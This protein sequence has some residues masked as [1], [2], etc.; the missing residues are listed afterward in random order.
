MLRSGLLLALLGSPLLVAPAQAR[1][2]DSPGGPRLEVRAGLDIPKVTIGELGPGGVL[3]RRAGEAK[4]A[5]GVEAGYDLSIAPEVIAGAYVGYS[6]SDDSCTEYQ[7]TTV[8]V[9]TATG[10][11]LTAGIRAGIVTGPFTLFAKGGYSNDRVNVLFSNG[12]DTIRLPRSG[13]LDG[14]HVGGGAEV[15]V[16]GG[17][18]LK[19]DYDYS[20]FDGVDVGFT[21]GPT[22]RTSI[23]GLH[24]HRVWLG[25]GFR[26]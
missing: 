24:R 3:P 26:F 13:N 2:G 20:R 10:R 8:A 22:D 14:F 4:L 21:G 7:N 15:D 16:S 5:Y 11:S 9:C 25:A 18:Y 19:A 17:F 1:D 12:T 23:T 6:N